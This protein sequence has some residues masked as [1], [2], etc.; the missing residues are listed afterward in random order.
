MNIKTP[1]CIIALLTPFYA[2]ASDSYVLA[3][4]VAFLDN[5][6]ETYEQPEYAYGISAFDTKG[7]G[8]WG[9]YGE[10]LISYDEG[11]YDYNDGTAT[12]KMTFEDQRLSFTAGATYGFTTN[13]YGLM[14]VGAHFDTL[15]TEPLLNSGSCDDDD[16]SNLCQ[17]KSKTRVSGQLGLL[18]VLPFGIGISGTYNTRQTATV[19]L[20]YQF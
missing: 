8:M 3:G 11:K 17:K 2:M 9:L 6:E 7:K 4:S 19:S 20:G 13:F 12:H 1:L 15:T 10:L 16:A 5:Q 14:G 18:Y